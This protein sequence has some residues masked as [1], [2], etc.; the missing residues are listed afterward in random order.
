LVY[1]AG[2]IMV[3][4]RIL[5]LLV[6]GCLFFVIVRSFRR[7]SLRILDAAL[8]LFVALALGT[9]SMAPS[10]VDP[11]LTELGFPPGDARRVIGVLVIATLLLFILVLRAFAKTDRLEDVVRDYTHRMAARAFVAEFG[12]VE[13]PPE[14]KLVVVIPALNEESSLEAVLK[15]VPK[16]VEGL[17]VESIVVSDGST[18]ATEEVAITNGA[19]VARCDLRQGQGAAVSLGYR[20]GLLRGATVV[21]TLDA[22]GQYVPEELPRLVKPILAG[23]AEVVHGSR[24]LGAYESPV[25]GRAQ[26]VKMLSWVTSLMARV[27][28]TDPA[29]GFRAFTPDALQRLR[30]RESQFHASEATLAAAKA[31]LR[32]KE[33]PCTFRERMAGTTKKPPLLR[34]GYGYTRSLFRTW[35]G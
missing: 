30:F 13:E 25:R 9:V 11:F 14:G 27:P 10:S 21:A 7:R 35:L 2:E 23:E 17:P 1:N 5:G 24:I 28:I 31:G 15:A 34:Y 3:L 22:D 6:A 8:G 20:L 12:K 4:L 16:E 29:S 18:D 33:V 32:V 26:G 19:L